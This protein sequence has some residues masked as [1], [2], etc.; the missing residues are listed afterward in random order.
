MNRRT[1][2]VAAFGLATAMM[3]TSACGAITSMVGGSGGTAANQLWTDVPQ[4]P[5]MTK[6][7]GDLPLPARMAMQAML[8]GM[9][10]TESGSVDNIEFLTF[11]TAKTPE[12]LRTFYSKEAMSALGWNL[13][14]LPG[15]TGA[16]AGAQ[17]VS[18]PGEFCI[19]GREAG[20]GKNTFLIIMA[21][22][23][24]GKAESTVYFYR[25]SGAKV[26]VQQQ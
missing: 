19:Y 25:I 4:M 5:G 1:S 14:D 20:T 2:L 10:S 11:T 9:A 12:D 6:Q 23:E 15:C 22:K 18:I 7:S 16:A 24:D 21:A 13:P 8:Q 17:G 26:N 3:L